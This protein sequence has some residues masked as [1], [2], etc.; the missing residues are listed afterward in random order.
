MYIIYLVYNNRNITRVTQFLFQL[1][2]LLWT[3]AE[4]IFILQVTAP[5]SARFVSACIRE[6]SKGF[7]YVYRKASP[8]ASFLLNKNHHQ[9][10]LIMSA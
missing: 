9:I 8:Q 10:E 3:A 6:N 4:T 1:L 5:H 2:L 7:I